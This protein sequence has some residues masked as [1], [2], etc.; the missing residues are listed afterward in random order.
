MVARAKEIK[1]KYRFAQRVGRL[2]AKVT[3]SRKNRMNATSTQ[4][5]PVEQKEDEAG[6]VEAHTEI[7]IQMEPISR[8]KVRVHIT[9]RKKLQPR[10]VYEGAEEE[11]AV[12]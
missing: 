4:L 11:M 3:P 7:V 9:N 5:A 2:M 10:F 1:R 8:R 6:R 12:G